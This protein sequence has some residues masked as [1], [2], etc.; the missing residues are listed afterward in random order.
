MGECS[1]VGIKKT[2][3]IFNFISQGYFLPHADE[4]CIYETGEVKCG[5]FTGQI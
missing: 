2:K 3:K 4:C 5:A 1:A